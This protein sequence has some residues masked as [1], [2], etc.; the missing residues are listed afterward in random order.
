MSGRGADYC[1][2]MHRNLISF[3]TFLD[4]RLFS[5][6]CDLFCTACCQRYA[7]VGSSCM[8]WLRR[9]PLAVCHGSLADIPVACTMSCVCLWNA[10]LGNMPFMVDI[11]EPAR[12]MNFSG[13]DSPDYQPLSVTDPVMLCV[14]CQP[15][16]LVCCFVCVLGV[17]ACVVYFNAASWLPRRSSFLCGWCSSHLRRWNTSETSTRSSAS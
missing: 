8:Q 12:V 9:Y 10:I 7:D 4:F 3:C 17:C 15:W 16:T 14:P 6:P 2:R 1:C 13:G 11:G 5:S